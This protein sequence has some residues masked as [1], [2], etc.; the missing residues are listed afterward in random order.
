MERLVQPA[1]A[2]GPHRRRAR[3]PRRRSRYGA[4][5]VPVHTHGFRPLPQQEYALLEKDAV[6]PRSLPLSRYKTFASDYLTGSGARALYSVPRPTAV[7]DPQLGLIQ[8]VMWNETRPVTEKRTGDNPIA[9]ETIL[10]SLQQLATI[11]PA[12]LRGVTVAFVELIA[13]DQGGNTIAE[14]HLVMVDV[15]KGAGTDLGYLYGVLGPEGQVADHEFAHMLSWRVCGEML[16]ADS[17][18]ADPVFSSLV[19]GFTFSTAAEKA[20]TEPG[21]YRGW[22]ALSG[23]PSGP[24]AVARPYGAR[25]PEE[26]QAVLIG[27]LVSSGRF[28]GRLYAPAPGVD[29]SHLQVQVALWMARVAKARPE[30]AAY[31]QL[32]GDLARVREVARARLEPLESQAAMLTGSIYTVYTST[33]PAIVALR[34]A[35]M[36]RLKAAED[37]ATTAL[38]GLGAYPPIVLNQTRQ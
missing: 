32:M 33:A 9:R 18:R 5:H 25:N 29:L 28:A 3:R 14:H 13:A 23:P 17:Q 15:V 2:S 36:D 37:T 35:G 7:P 19:P 22:S 16:D 11:P 31:L 1:G 26:A 34:R 20:L 30:T 38:T 24:A 21:T 10:S 4:H 8:D 6:G 27:E 12:D